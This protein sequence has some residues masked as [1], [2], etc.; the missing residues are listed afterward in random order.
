MPQLH[1]FGNNNLSFFSP[2]GSY[3]PANGLIVCETSDWTKEEWEE[4][5]E[6][7]DN[8]RAELALKLARK[9]S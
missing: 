8:E 3:G 7:S 1:N 9:L 6:V 2:D 5:E 4:I